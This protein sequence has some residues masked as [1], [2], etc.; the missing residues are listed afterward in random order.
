MSSQ[1]EFILEPLPLRQLLL[2]A[3]YQ[4]DLRENAVM[5]IVQDYHP[6]QFQPITVGMRD[7]STLHIVDGQHRVAAARRMGWTHVPCMVFES[8]GFEHEAQVFER[9]QTARAGLTIAQRWKARIA[10]K[11]PKATAIQ[12]IVS[13]VGLRLS[14]TKA[15]TSLYSFTACERAYERGN[16]RDTL[17][18]IIQA[19]D[20]DP[21]GFRTNFIDGT[22]VFLASLQ[23]AG[24]ELNMD[25]LS[26][27][28]GKIKPL[29]FLRETSVIGNNSAM[30]MHRLLEAYN[31][32]MRTGRIKIDDPTGFINS[33]RTKAAQETRNASEDE[34]SG[35]FA[36]LP[37]ERRKELSR[38]GHEA[39]ARARA[40]RRR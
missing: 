36:T 24:H 25:R 22:S 29:A 34:N 11:E 12:D 13:S 28:L 40:A 33:F 3:R 4:R 20:Y 21:T 10:R 39:Q 7:D 23:S 18:L 19:W 9:L 26:K 14:N 5:A 37:E 2:D 30:F 1:P 32:G 17:V 6:E 31:S 35:S 15:P 16:L 27:A 38:L 8:Q